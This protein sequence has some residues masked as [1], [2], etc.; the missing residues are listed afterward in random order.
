[1]N[2]ILTS[3]LLY[4]LN[5]E[6]CPYKEVVIL[7]AEIEDHLRDASAVEL[8]IG[9]ASP[10]MVDAL[11]LLARKIKQANVPDVRETDLINTGSTMY[12]WVHHA[13]KQ[14]SIATIK[15]RLDSSA[16]KYEAYSLVEIPDDDK[17]RIQ[18]LIN[19]IREK[20]L[21][22]EFADEA[23]TTRLLKKLEALQAELHKQIS[24]VDRFLG[25]AI[26]ARTILSKYNTPL[27]MQVVRAIKEIA[28][29]ALD[30]QAVSEGLPPGSD[31]LLLS[32]N[33]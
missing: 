4:T 9:D 32:I 29:T 6:E 24:D 19:E 21:E 22:N 13:K 16:D 12:A 3:Q 15:R 23:F 30:A 27:G 2:H 8:H 17:Q 10:D 26:T 31:T 18:A 25:L 28:K 14:A 1:M 5:C 7:G 11:A 33:D 20:I